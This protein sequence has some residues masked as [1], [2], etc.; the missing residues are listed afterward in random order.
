MSRA[1]HRPPA[2]RTLQDQKPRMA[3][4][5]VIGNDPETWTFRLTDCATLLE[6]TLVRVAY[7][8]RLVGEDDLGMILKPEPG[9]AAP[10]RD[11]LED[12]LNAVHERRAPRHGRARSV[13]ASLT[14]RS[15]HS[16][17]D[18]PGRD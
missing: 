2:A 9:H 7:A 15:R 4:I 5:K 16:P 17:H 18:P 10:T 1:A 3:A 11:E 13:D 12:R 14:I 8:A 6:L